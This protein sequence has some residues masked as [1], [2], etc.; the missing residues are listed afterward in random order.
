[1]IGLVVAMIPP[2]FFFQSLAAF[3]VA[4]LLGANRFAA[5]A[6]TFITN[7]L[8]FYIYLINYVVGLPFLKFTIGWDSPSPAELWRI[9]QACETFGQVTRQIASIGWDI[10]VPMTL[11]GFVTSGALAVP[12][13]V[14]TR[15]WVIDRR[16]RRAAR[17]AGR[18]VP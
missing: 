18:R 4:W 16:E 10:F 7:P 9:F 8:T 13:Y 17:M 1:M 3:G 15:R 14:T 2:P 12:V 11:G 5:A 6:A